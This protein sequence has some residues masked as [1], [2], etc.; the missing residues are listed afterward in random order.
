MTSNAMYPDGSVA[1]ANNYCRNPD[2]SAVGL[3]CYTTDPSVRWEPCDVALCGQ[4]SQG[5]KP[6]F[7]YPS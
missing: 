7:H 4:S 1:A 3:W 2:G 5:F 6:G